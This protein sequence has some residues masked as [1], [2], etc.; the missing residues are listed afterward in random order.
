MLAGDPGARP[1]S[2]SSPTRSRRRQPRLRNAARARLA[3]KHEAMAATLAAELLRRYPSD[4]EA[5]EVADAILSNLTPRLAQLDVTCSE[6]CTLTL[7][8]RA[9][10]GKPA[11]RHTFFAQPGA[12]TIAASFDGDLHA[13]QQITAR[14]GQTTTLSLDAPP[15]SVVHP[16]PRPVAT[17]TATLPRDDTGH[18][19]G[20][21]WVV[22]HRCAHGRPRRRRDGRRHDD[23]RPARPDQGGGGTRR[24]ATAMSLYTDA[25]S[26]AAAHQRPHRRDRRRRD[27]HDRAG[28]RH[29]LVASSGRRSASR[30]RPAVRHWSS[31]VTSSPFARC[32]R[33]CDAR[34]AQYVSVDSRAW[35]RTLGAEARNHDCICERIPS[36]DYHVHDRQLR[37]HR[38]SSRPAAWARCF[39][40]SSAVRSRS[41][42][43]SCSRSSTRAS[44]TTRCSSRCSSTRRKLVGHA[45][46]PEHH[47][48]LRAVRGRRLRDG[49]GV[50]ARRHRAALAARR[51]RGGP[52]AAV[53][54]G[55]ADRDRRVRGALPRVQPAR[56]GR[57]A[58]SHRAS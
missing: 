51:R 1:T 21:Q 11:T 5:R 31:V 20:R 33:F 7:D 4:P 17:L 53:R 10:N 48:H 15:R 38:A 42:A 52:D 47:P 27:R 45:H 14:A 56:R 41:A 3:A 24:R 23:A 55:G 37:G 28:V 46:A 30:A 35:R 40:R 22:A 9:I 19:V 26:T 54:A 49:D 36:G 44:R 18:G 57:R 8:A 43:T 34:C 25:R 6:A 29:E 12:R 58:T 50:R 2:T 32:G 13:S 39:S 16:E